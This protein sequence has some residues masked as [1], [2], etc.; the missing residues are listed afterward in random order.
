MA[1]L[2]PKQKQKVIADRVDGMS[3]RALA[4]KY[5]VST[6]TIQNVCNAD[7]ELAQKFTEKKEANTNDVLSYMDSKVD[8][9]KLLSN[10]VFDE[11][12]NPTTNRDEL[13]GLPLEKLM[14]V[15]GIATDKM[16]KS[17]EI[18]SKCEHEDKP[19]PVTIII[20]RGRKDA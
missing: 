18:H 15:F 8:A 6:T 2:D 17:K 7:P 11:R 3:F 12:L 19:D 20:K 5:K 9:F 13:A 10:Y 4:A 16:L 1:K 14:S